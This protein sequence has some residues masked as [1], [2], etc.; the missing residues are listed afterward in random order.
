MT[1]IKGKYDHLKCS[2]SGIVPVHKVGRTMLFAGAGKDMGIRSWNLLFALA[3]GHVS[4]NPACEPLNGAENILPMELCSPKPIPMLDVDW[5]DGKVPALPATWWHDLAEWMLKEE[6]DRHM[7]VFCFGGHGRTGTFLSIIVGLTH[8]EEAVRKSPV[9]WVRKSYCGKAVETLSQIKY[10]E[11]VCGI[12]MTD[13]PSDIANVVQHHAAS[14]YY[15][16]A[17]T[18]A[19][20]MSHYP[21]VADDD[22]EPKDGWLPGWWKA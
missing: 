22:W 1:K 9:E 18:G 17:K 21:E 7:G 12:E 19:D 2:H 6:T 3:Q 20:A 13:E 4:G 14:H 5:P 15:G 8:P 16:A 10:I 11:L